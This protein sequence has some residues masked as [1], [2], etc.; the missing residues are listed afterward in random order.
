MGASREDPRPKERPK[1]QQ[2]IRTPTVNPILI[3]VQLALPVTTPIW[4][5]ISQNHKIIMPEANM[6]IRSTGIRIYT[7]ELPGLPGREN[8]SK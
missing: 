6:H 4:A 7:W 3:A 8:T 1:G 2:P 5:E